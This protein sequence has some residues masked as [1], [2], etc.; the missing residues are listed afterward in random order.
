MPDLLKAHAELRQTRV[1]LLD[2]EAEVSELFDKY[3][4]RKGEAERKQQVSNAVVGGV[5]ARLRP[6]MCAGYKNGKV[7]YVWDRNK[8]EKEK[9]IERRG[10]EIMRR[11]KEELKTRGIHKKASTNP[12]RLHF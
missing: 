1:E 9:E 6:D 5:L 11:R 12:A 8:A 3:R 7:V 4:H 10:Q 2:A